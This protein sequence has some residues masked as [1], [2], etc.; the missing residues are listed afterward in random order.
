MTPEPRLNCFSSWSPKLSPKNFLK[1]GSSMKGLLGCLASLVVNTFTTDGMARLDASRKVPAA[2]D[3]GAAS[4]IGTVDEFKC[5]IWRVP[6]MP[7]AQSG[8]RLATMNQIAKPTVTVCANNSHRRRIGV[9]KWMN[10]Q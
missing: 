6:I 1:N 10:E 2:V 3:V 8:F 5:A 9:N 4:R 7:A